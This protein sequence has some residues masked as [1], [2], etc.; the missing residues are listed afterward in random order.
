[1]IRRP[2]RST[3]CISS[4][5]SDVYKRQSY[6]CIN[7]NIQKF[8]TMEETKSTIS[9]NKP[10]PLQKEQRTKFAKGNFPTTDR[11]RIHMSLQRKRRHLARM[12]AHILHGLHCTA[13]KAN[14][15]RKAKGANPLVLNLHRRH[16]RLLQQFCFQ[17]SEVLVLLWDL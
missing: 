15:P 2:P 9:E 4:A 11:L 17:V 7:F 13:S 5:A 12:S 8:N 14:A 3:H 1:M 16:T 10:K 6:D